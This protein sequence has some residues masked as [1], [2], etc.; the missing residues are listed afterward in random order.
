[1]QRL[2]AE[3]IGTFALIFA[4][5]GAI[6]VNQVAGGPI[7]HVGIALT[8]GLIVLAMIYAVGDISGAHLNPAVTIGFWAARRFP[9]SRVLSYLIAQAMGGLAASLILRILFWDNEYLG[10][11]IP[12][13]SWW[14]SFILEVILTF[15]LMF[16]VMNVATGA[17]EKGIMAGVAI[18]AV[19]GLEAM[20]AGP[21]CGASMN[22]IRSV[23]PAIVSGHLQEVWIYILAPTLGA[24][25][26]VWGW[27]LIQERPE[28]APAQIASEAVQESV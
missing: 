6:I 10:S 27:Q 2:I 28:L 14:Q 7:T 11:T 4:G 24:L 23:A 8:W 9:A 3:A 17:K 16:T 12:A 20:F 26:G 21:I 25:A 22:P 5:T 13:G 19:V 18:G 1:M 15:M